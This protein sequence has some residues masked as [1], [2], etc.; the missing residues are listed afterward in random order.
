MNRS[1]PVAMNA[2]ISLIALLG[3]G[4][5]VVILWSARSRHAQNGAVTVREYGE[6]GRPTLSW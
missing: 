2:L 3:V 5:V 4:L 6:S 1:E